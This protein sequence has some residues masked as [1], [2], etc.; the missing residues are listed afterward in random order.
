MS[1]AIAG[2]P[3]GLAALALGIT[4]LMPL[5]GCA[6]KA[7][8]RLRQPFAPPSQQD[9][10]LAGRS[11]Y[12]TTTAD[13]QTCLLTFPLPGA[14][15]GPR[16]FVIYVSAPDELGRM[17]VDPQDPRVVRGFLVQEVGKLTGRADFAEGE[18]RF[19]KV[20]L[21]PRFRRIGFNVRCDDG[22]VIQGQALVESVP[23]K[24]RTFEREY[25]ADVALLG[26]PE[27]QP[28]AAQQTRPRDLRGP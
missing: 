2:T 7:E 16:A 5:A 12:H 10:K 3:H 4:L 20:W 22:T 21:A 26:S 25:A 13:R 19:R 27:S 9:L 11:A 24:V 15:N 8:L 6:P 1:R 18:V 28:A 23:T 17:P 14:A